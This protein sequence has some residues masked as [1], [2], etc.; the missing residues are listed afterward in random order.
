M[1]L[2][3]AAF[4]SVDQ[5]TLNLVRYGIAALAL[6]PIFLLREGRAAFD[7]EGRFVAV[8]VIGVAGMAMSALLVV[9][10]LRYALPENAVVI[11]ALQPSLAALADWRLHGRRPPVGTQVCI[12]VAFVGVIMVVTKGEPTIALSPQEL[13]G[14]LIANNLLT[15]QPR[16]YA[17][18]PASQAEP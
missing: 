13:V 2:A 14:A 8:A 11:L 7:Y 15:R 18:V 4:E 16:S 6:T 17:Y 9:W 1:P 5:I 12:A 3:K 10:G